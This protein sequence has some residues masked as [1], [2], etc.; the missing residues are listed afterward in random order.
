[1][2]TI[3]TLAALVALAVPAAAQAARP[4]I[5]EAQAS[6]AARVWIHDL[7]D[8]ANAAEREY[9]DEM[10][11]EAIEEG[12]EIDTSEYDSFITRAGLAEDGCDVETRYRALCDVELTYDDGT[13]DEFSFDVIV[14]RKGT[15]RVVG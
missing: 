9:R 11:I 6:H 7:Q 3:I 15:Y 1:M 4:T 12:T 10:A 2:K 13:T 8:E 5:D 14:T